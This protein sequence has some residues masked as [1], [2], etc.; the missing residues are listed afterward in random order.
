MVGKLQENVTFL[1]L[2][3]ANI[4]SAFVC[5]SDGTSCFQSKRQGAPPYPRVR[6][7]VGVGVGRERDH[8]IFK[9]RSE[10]ETR[11]VP[12]RNKEQKTD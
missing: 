5:Q 11:D 6:V 3:C 10:T 2:M 7:C 9:L 12:R 1:S 4:V 8:R